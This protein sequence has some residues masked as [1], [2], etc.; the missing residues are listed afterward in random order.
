MRR[1]CHYSTACAKQ[2]MNKQ[3]AVIVPLISKMT[4]RT[5]LQAA[6]CMGHDG[7]FMTVNTTDQN[8]LDNMLQCC[9]KLNK[10]LRCWAFS[11]SCLCTSDNFFSN[12]NSCSCIRSDICKQHTQPSYCIWKDSGADLLHPDAFPE[13]HPMVTGHCMHGKRTKQTTI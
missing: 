4:V 7:E 9:K 11:W 5:A 13:D 6:Y 8:E 10:T 1:P 12:S 3:T 2:W